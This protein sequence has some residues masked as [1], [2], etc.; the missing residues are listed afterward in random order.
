LTEK[1]RLLPNAA[2]AVV[3]VVVTSGLLFLLYW[4]LLRQLGA[5]ALGVW[6]LLMAATSLANISNMGFSGGVV[7]FVSRYLAKGSPEDAASAV[8][9]AFLSI[10]AVIGVVGVAMWVA[11]EWVLALVIPPHWIDEARA[12]L[13]YSMIALW[14]SAIGSVVHSA[15]DGCHRSD[16][17]SL[18]TISSQPVLLIGA[19]LLTP[20][21]GLQGIAWAQ[22]AQYLVWIVVGWLLLKRQ[23]APLPAIPYRW[24]RRFFQEMWRYGVNF[25]AVTLMLVLSEPLAKGLLSFHT[26]LSAVAY[27]EMANRLI[28]QTRSVLISANQVIVPYYSQLHTQ[29]STQLGDIYLRN[30]KL[31]SLLGSMLFS[32]VLA[33]APVVSQLWIGHLETQFL[34]FVGLLSVGWFINTLAAPAYFANLGM[35]Y[36]RP[37]VAGHFAMMLGMIAVGLSMGP[38]FKPYGSAM[39]WPVGLLIGSFIIDAGFLQNVRLERHQWRRSLMLPKMSFHLIVGAAAGVVSFKLLQAQTPWA[40]GGALGVIAAALMLI[41]LPNVRQ[42]IAL[43]RISPPRPD[44]STQP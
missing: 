6:T 36:M 26:N 4:F 14:L 31:V 44:A 28:V 29:G 42:V 33:V 19:I 30:L 20:S 12:I 25:Q 40:T 9:T 11:I 37:N 1:R 21:M 43:M 2:L 8:E 5:E 15:L 13:P 35:A 32:A 24:S 16:L 27:F 23:L 41:C 18:S 10:A 22:I 17:R 39:A 7:R 38:F 3:Q 34:V